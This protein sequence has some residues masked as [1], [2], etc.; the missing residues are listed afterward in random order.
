MKII[1]ASKSP[2]RRRMF[3]EL[4]IPHLLWDGDADESRTKKAVEGLPPSDIVEALAKCKA[5]GC[6]D[7]VKDKDCLII[8]ADTVVA[9]GDKILGKPVDDEDA[10]NMLKS[11]SG[12]VHDVYS[13]ICAIY[14]GRSVTAYEKTEIKFREIT[15]S[16]IRRYM[17]TGEHRDKA[18]SYGIQEKGG[19]FVERVWGDINNVVG[20]PVLKL[21]NTV[22]E[23]FGIDLFDPDNL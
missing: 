6:F 9:L 1:L 21:R 12:S 16:E 18:G 8:G 23:S 19:Y 2:R 5:A 22:L 10:F 3:E 20:L 7:D 15:D 13:G 14:G 11:M 4:G 17:A